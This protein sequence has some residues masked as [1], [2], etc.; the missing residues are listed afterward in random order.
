[1]LPSFVKCHEKQLEWV[2]FSISTTKVSLLGVL[3]HCYDGVQPST[4]ASSGYPSDQKRL[5]AERDSAS[6][7]ASSAN[8]SDKLDR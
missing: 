8:F 3:Q 6:R 2:S 7:E 1:M 4:Q 5:E